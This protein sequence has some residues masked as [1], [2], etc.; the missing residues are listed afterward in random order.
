[1]EMCGQTG[2]DAI[3]ADSCAPPGS[4]KITKTKINQHKR[5]AS[6]SYK[7]KHAKHYECE[8]I[9]NKKVKYRAACG[10]KTAASA[11]HVA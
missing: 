11:R 3:I 5:T 9:C 4:T 2:S 1:M 8:L 10:S 7:A 6:F